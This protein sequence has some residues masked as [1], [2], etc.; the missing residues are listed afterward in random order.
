MDGCFFVLFWLKNSGEAKGC[1]AQFQ[2]DHHHPN[3]PLQSIIL[4][5][6]TARHK[7][8]GT[9][10]PAEYEGV[11]IEQ[12]VSLSLLPFSG[13]SSQCQDDAATQKKQQQQHKQKR[14]SDDDGKERVA[15]LSML[16]YIYDDLLDG[17]HSPFFSA[18][19]GRP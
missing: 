3:K 13:H 15:S 10:F 11:S 7:Q 12:A 1:F 14:S 4:A 5:C 6:T 2:L 18:Y 19:M 8:T 17:V 9:L 16:K